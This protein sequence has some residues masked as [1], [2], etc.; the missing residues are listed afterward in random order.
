MR[1]F[2]S[3]QIPRVPCTSIPK[4]FGR[5]RVVSCVRVSSLPSEVRATV[6]TMSP[7]VIFGQPAPSLSRKPAALEA[8]EVTLASEWMSAIMQS[9]AMLWVG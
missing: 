2:S 6:E 3:S 1:W 9:G 8:K 5:G 4:L 7:R